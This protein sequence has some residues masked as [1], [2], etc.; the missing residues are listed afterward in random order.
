MYG[1]S[2]KGADSLMILLGPSKYLVVVRQ[3]INLP[4][5]LLM[6]DEAI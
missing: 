5:L 3:G 4:Q 2:L 6:A 1:V